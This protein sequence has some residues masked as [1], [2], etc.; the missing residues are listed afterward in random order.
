MELQPHSNTIYIVS[1]YKTGTTYIDSLWNESVS[2]HEP[3]QLYSLR[4]LGQNFEEDFLKR[5]ALLDLKIECSGFWSLFL[6][7]LPKP[8]T[9][10][11]YI[12]VLRPPSEWVTS[13]IKHFYGLR[14]IGYNYINDYYWIRLLGYDMLPVLKNGKEAEIY[15]LISDLYQINFDILQSALKNQAIFF[16]NMEDLDSLAI[17]LG[18]I[19]GI[20]P[21]F[22][23]SWRRVAKHKPHFKIPL[24]LEMD[25]K[26]QIWLKSIPERRFMVV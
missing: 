24:D 9:L 23:Q 20:E 16:V 2:K 1:P 13:V 14:T 5:E 8:E 6:E 26:Y 10:Y 4:G 21:N 25:K 3:L 19:I 17:K 15:K 12:Y 18:Q 11:K 7:R 22:D